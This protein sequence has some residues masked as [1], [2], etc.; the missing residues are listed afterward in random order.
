MILHPLAVSIQSLLHSF[1]P[2]K[3]WARCLRDRL[4]QRFSDKAA[5]FMQSTMSLIEQGPALMDWRTASNERHAVSRLHLQH[6]RIL[7]VTGEGFLIQLQEGHSRLH[8]PIGA[9]DGALH[10]HCHRSPTRLH[11]LLT[12]QVPLSKNAREGACIQHLPLPHTFC[13]FCCWQV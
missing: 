12:G 9:K 5:A 6:S 11:M 8:V 1:W 4:S 10:R 2:F 7:A 13:V 3:T